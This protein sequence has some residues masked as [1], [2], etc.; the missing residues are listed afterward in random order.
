MN[1]NAIEQKDASDDDEFED[2]DDVEKE[3]KNDDNWPNALARNR[4]PN[5]WPKVFHSNISEFQQVF[6]GIKGFYP[7]NYIPNMNN[8][9]K[10]FY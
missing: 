3:D 6:N 9:G 2:D 5:A 10:K 8:A 7:K 4:I 1:D